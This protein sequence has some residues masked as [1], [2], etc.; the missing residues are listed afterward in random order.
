MVRRTWPLTCVTVAALGCGAGAAQPDAGTRRVFVDDVNTLATPTGVMTAPQDQLDPTPSVLAADGPHVTTHVG[1]GRY[2][3]RSVPLGPFVAQIGDSFFETSGSEL[4]AGRVIVGHD[5]TTFDLGSELSV[6]LD[7]LA[8]WS[9]GD[10][11]TIVSA[12]ARARTPLAMT[13][14]AGVTAVSTTVTVTGDAII[15]TDQGDDALIYQT[16][17]IASAGGA[18]SYTRIVA[19]AVLPSLHRLTPLTASL[20]AVAAD[21]SIT[22]SADSAAFLAETDGQPIDHM[23]LRLNVMS[24]ASGLVHATAWDPT[25]VDVDPAGAPAGTF[26]YANPFAAPFW[27]PYARFDVVYRVDN[28]AAGTS[29]WAQISTLVGVDQISA[30]IAPLVGVPRGLRVN[31]SDAAVVQGATTTPTLSWDP[32][33]T[34]HVDSYRIVV[35]RVVALPGSPLVPVATFWTTRTSFVV[36]QVFLTGIRYVAL[37]GAVAMPNTDRSTV[38]FRD[39]LP[40][41]LAEAATGVFS[42]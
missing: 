15:D 14:A 16:S 29:I 2:E 13:P 19:S 20:V 27:T 33:L 22:L 25:L 36:P 28:A 18:P 41:G 21:Q 8:P 9:A 3:A 30:P 1:P 26:A 35:Y 11:L 6:Q 23:D 39:S 32:P 5:P 42:P 12:L 40:I 4:D 7:G 34:G 31:G 38:L 10:G 24:G 17:T 37:V